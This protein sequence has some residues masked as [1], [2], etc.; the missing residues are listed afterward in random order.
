MSQPC[1]D[2]QSPAPLASPT[3]LR[4][5]L[6]Q[7]HFEAAH[8]MAQELLRR[9]PQSGEAIALLERCEVSRGCELKSRYNAGRLTLKWTLQACVLAPQRVCVQLHIFDAGAATSQGE[10]RE[11]RCNA[12]QGKITVP[13][14]I[15]SGACASY[16]ALDI[17]AAQSTAKLS[18]VLAVGR[19]HRWHRGIERRVA[20]L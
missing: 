18:R 1:P 3:L 8:G 2:L 13:L 4:L 5:Y 6:G 11:I 12:E 17:D 7:A 15:E 14:N 10:H 16:L 19:V 9:E 20:Q